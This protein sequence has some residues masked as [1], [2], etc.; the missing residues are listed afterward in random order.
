[1]R[2]QRS[3]GQVACTYCGARDEPAALLSAD[4]RGVR[5][6]YC[7]A[8]CAT[9]HR[10]AVELTEIL[11]S[12][13]DEQAVGDSGLCDEHLVEHLVEHL[14]HGVVPGDSPRA[15]PWRQAG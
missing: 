7:D 14:E 11:C 10:Q 9:A 13:C 15:Q 3:G 1:V 6:D 5:Y 4:V 8:A 2:V 12:G